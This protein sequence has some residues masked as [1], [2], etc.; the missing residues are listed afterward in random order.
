MQIGADQ[1]RNHP[2][3]LLCA[4]NQQKRLISQ[5]DRRE[6]LLLASSNLPFQCLPAM[7][8]QTKVITNPSR[9]EITINGEALRPTPWKKG[10]VVH[11]ISHSQVRSL[12]HSPTRGGSH[13]LVDGRII[14][15]WG[16]DEVLNTLLP[17]MTFDGAAPQDP[18]TTYV[19]PLPPLPPKKRIN[20]KPSQGLL[21]LSATCERLIAAMIEFSEGLARARQVGGQD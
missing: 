15:R 12:G 2:F 13:A 19:T 7:N 9:F 20:K 5:N 18:I 6:H 17:Q 4:Y 11:H 10:R 14:I 1:T 8:Q 16:T 3:V 21:E